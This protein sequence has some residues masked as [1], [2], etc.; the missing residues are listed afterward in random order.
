MH[1]ERSLSCRNFSVQVPS[2]AVTPPL[3]S[4]AAQLEKSAAKIGQNVSL[5][6][7]IERPNKCV[8]I[9][10]LLIIIFCW[11][12][13]IVLLGWIE[14]AVLSSASASSGSRVAESGPSPWP[15]PNILPRLLQRHRRLGENMDR[16]RK[17]VCVLATKLAT[18]GRKTGGTG[19]QHS[20]A[21]YVLRR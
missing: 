17:S 18:Q 21:V 1:G 20:C 11:L 5:R 13:N 19:R 14:L 3:W 7:D 12:R 4:A 2:S 6:F 8:M 16:A 10:A 9:L 15:D